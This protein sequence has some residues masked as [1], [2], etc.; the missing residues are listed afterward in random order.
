M[1]PQ[2]ASE[3]SS[4][5]ASPPPPVRKQL[6][7]LSAA[8]K[9]TLLVTFCLAQYMDSF[10]ISA[11]FAAT[12]PTGGFPYFNY[13]NVRDVAAMHAAALAVPEAGGERVICNAGASH[14]RRL[15][16]ILR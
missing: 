16:T 10:N 15:H 5:T 12:P 14:R 13:V 7:E 8:R 6:S 11:L 4:V 1:A 3:S 9:I 2:P